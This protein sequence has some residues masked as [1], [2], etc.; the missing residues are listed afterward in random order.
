MSSGVGSVGIGCSTRRERI[1]ESLTP[2]RVCIFEIGEIGTWVS[3]ESGTGALVGD[4]GCRGGIVIAHW[5]ENERFLL[6]R[7]FCL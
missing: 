5:E 6:T 3:E 4:F 2:P 1:G 7:G